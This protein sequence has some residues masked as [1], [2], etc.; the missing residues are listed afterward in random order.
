[1]AACVFLN[2]VLI[3]LLI[4]AVVGAALQRLTINML[5]KDQDAERIRRVR[6]ERRDAAEY[7]DGP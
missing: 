4:V 2:A 7:G 1:M 5:R 3:V 6:E